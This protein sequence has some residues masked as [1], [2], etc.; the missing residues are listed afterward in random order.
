MTEQQCC[1][2]QLVAASDHFQ[3]CAELREQGGL[4]GGP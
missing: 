1:S 4:F 2:E 3:P